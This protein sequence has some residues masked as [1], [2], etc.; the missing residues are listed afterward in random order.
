[1]NSS[2]DKA[3]ALK[4]AKILL[5][6]DSLMNQ[7]LIKAL[8]KKW[9]LNLT[10][11][12]NGKKAVEEQKI[13]DYDIILMDIQMPEMDGIEATKKIRKESQTIIIIA[14]TAH[15]FES[16]KKKCFDIGMNDFIAKPFEEDELLNKLL[17]YYNSSITTVQKSKNPI[18]ESAGKLSMDLSQ[19]TSIGL[20]TPGFSKEMIE[21]YL[22]QTAQQLEEIK[23]NKSINDFFKIG[24]LAHSMKASFSMLNCTLLS[25]QAIEIE[26]ICNSSTI[27][28]NKLYS[29]I[30]EFEFFITESFSLIQKMAKKEGI[31]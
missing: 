13:G 16:E 1:M 12:D 3:K 19:I 4:N 9:T 11:V 31:L 10:I 18:Q 7:L 6:E 26:G 22:N 20:T 15:F 25:T 8:F 30:E 5:A 2:T 14:I 27:D 28:K 24:R 17:F 29:L 21:L 23:K